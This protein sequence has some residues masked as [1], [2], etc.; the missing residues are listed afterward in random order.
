MLIYKIFRTPE[1]QALQADGST[2]GAPIDLSDGY[3]HFST[4]EQAAETAAK[5]FAG[6]EGLWLAAVEAD[7]LGDD[8]KWEP[9]RGGALFPHLYRPLRL[10]D[11]VWAW[12]LPLEDGAHVFPAEMV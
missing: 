10:D 9:S 7:T 5:H 8:L 3:I 2:L 1:W 12:P 4:A 6:V 11:V